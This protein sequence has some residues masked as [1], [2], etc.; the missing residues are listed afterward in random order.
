VW[1][2]AWALVSAMN[3][4]ALLTANDAAHN[5][6][7]EH[8]AFFCD[9]DADGDCRLTF[10]EFVEALPNHVRANRPLS[11]LRSW[12]DTIDA[13]GDDELSLNEMYRWSLRAAAVASGAGLVGLF[14]KYCNDGDRL[15]RAAFR[16]AASDCDFRDYADDLFDQLPHN[17]DGTVS[18]LEL[19]LSEQAPAGLKSFLCAMCWENAREDGTAALGQPRGER[20]R[21]ERRG[22]RGGGA[23]SW[24]FAADEPEGVRR[25][26]G[27]ML[28]WHSLQ[29]S[30]ILA[31]LD[32][33]ADGL[34]SREEFVCGLVRTLGFT[35]D[36]AVLETTY[37]TQLDA[38]GGGAVDL[39][40]LDM[41]IRGGLIDQVAAREAAAG[42]RLSF[43]EPPSALDDT[44]ES[45]RAGEAGAIVH[46]AWSVR[47]LR[48]ALQA[49]LH[50]GQLAADD[51]LSVWDESFADGQRDGR[52][53]RREW[54]MHFKRLMP[55]G[56]PDHLWYKSVR[57]AVV[58]AFAALDLHTERALPLTRVR[59]W[60]EAAEEPPATN[61]VADYTA[62]GAADDATYGAKRVWA[63]TGGQ[64]GG[65][66]DRA[67]QRGPRRQPEAPKW[68]SRG[69]HGAIK[70]Q[71]RGNQEAPK[72]HPSM[73]K[74]RSAANREAFTRQSIGG[75]SSPEETE[76]SHHGSRTQSHGTI[77]LRGGADRIDGGEAARFS[78]PGSL[79]ARA[80]LAAFDDASTEA[81]DGITATMRLSLPRRRR[82][83]VA[84]KDV[85][86][87]PVHV[88]TAPPAALPSLPPTSR[89]LSDV[90]AAKHGRRRRALTT[91][92]SE[93][94]RLAT[95]P[96]I[97]Y[98]AVSLRPK[99]P[100]RPP[101]PADERQC[102][103]WRRDAALTW[104][105]ERVRVHDV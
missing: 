16:R 104:L 53:T 19:G 1:K 103:S 82:A 85:V 33:S 23:A 98:N 28:R 54:L 65:A 58:E 20:D 9:A 92:L 81:T 42:L 64:D 69:N 90:A 25:E 48:S 7:K 27:K 4:P 87:V 63:H 5:A 88:E 32:R 76:A 86:V 47:R 22:A 91:S 71:P 101:R 45:S 73:A 51:M 38:S 8:C 41:W 50:E 11:E 31:A 100:A 105:R 68:Q 62:D 83:A 61:A 59:R 99:P 43:D 96:L 94:T 80:Q 35:G 78:T 6:M 77:Y 44:P 95:L 37:D 52:I 79:E 74:S 26:L 60:L 84:R 30:S 18:Y 29:L 39:D 21:S 55:R 56:T 67:A 3:A 14:K 12:F 89:L 49:A 10:P 15:D 46:G 93:P 34:L 75:A 102:H 17:A 72:R 36:R 24:T 2:C 13:D 66:N 70:R 40:R 57:P 97:A